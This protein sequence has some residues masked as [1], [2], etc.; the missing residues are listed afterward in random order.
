MI[1]KE[2]G[3][4]ALHEMLRAID[5]E[6]AEAIHKNNVKRVIRAIEIYKTS[7]KTKTELDRLSLLAEP[8]YD[9]TVI[10]LRYNDRELLL[11]RINKRVD[12]MLE[13]GLLDETRE[14]LELG[15]FEK[16]TTATQAIGYKEMLGFIRGE[17]S[18]D[19]A[20]ESLKLATRKYAKRQMTWFS[21][22]KYVEWIDADRDGSVRE[23]KDILFDV[24]SLLRQKEFEC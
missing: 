19:E 17:M 2:K 3:N 20:A 15:V 8:K 4:D 6:S 23:G 21:A 16:N 1:A 24:L 22:K 12:I 7:G 5:P 10:G 18:F 11:D 13:G 9:A 14:L